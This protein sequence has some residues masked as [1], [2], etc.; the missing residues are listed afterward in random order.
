M[1]FT[2]EYR[3]ELIERAEQAMAGLGIKT[4]GEYLVVCQQRHRSYLRLHFY[5]GTQQVACPRC[6][7]PTRALELP[8]VR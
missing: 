2:P 1:L 6:D 7:A 3:A 5:D 8:P 4:E